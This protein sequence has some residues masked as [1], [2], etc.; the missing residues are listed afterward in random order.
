MNLN[1]VCSG[2]KT[3]SHLSFRTRLNMAPLSAP[4]APSDGPRRS[5]AESEPANYAV[6]P[7]GVLAAYAV[8]LAS[9]G[10]LFVM[11]LTGG[12]YLG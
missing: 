3:F 8:A 5:S 1:I 10:F 11:A 9:T 4:P 7:W 12:I 2:E 6:M